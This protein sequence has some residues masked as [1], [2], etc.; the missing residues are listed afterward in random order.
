MKGNVDSTSLAFFRDNT[1]V[2]VYPDE[3]YD[4][5]KIVYFFCQRKVGEITIDGLE[6]AS[7]RF[8]G[9]EKTD[10]EF[11]EHIKELK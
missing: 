8:G 1:S 7:M 3:G 11:K 5:Y 10:M 9:D 6:L 2:F 4:R